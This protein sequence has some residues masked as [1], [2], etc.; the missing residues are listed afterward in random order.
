[1]LTTLDQLLSYGNVEAS[2]ESGVTKVIFIGKPFVDGVPARLVVMEN[3]A[4]D[5]LLSLWNKFVDELPRGFP[6]HRRG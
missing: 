4:D 1:M 5:A 2:R 6:D 3:D